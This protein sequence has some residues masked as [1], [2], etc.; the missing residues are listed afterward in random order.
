MSYQLPPLPYAQNALEPY[1]T[2]KLMSFHYGKHHQGYVDKY[3]ELVTG[4]PMADQPLEKVIKDTFEKLDQ[5]NFSIM[6]LKFLI[7]IFSGTA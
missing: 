6:L 4:T 1:I 7:T 2:S 3:N 5:K